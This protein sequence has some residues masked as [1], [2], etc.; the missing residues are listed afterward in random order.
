MIT[1]RVGLHFSV[2]WHLGNRLHYGNGLEGKQQPIYHPKKFG[3]I[4]RGA[5]VHLTVH[6]GPIGLPLIAKHTEHQEPN[7]FT[8]N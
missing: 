8:D 4:S 5:E 1:M 6:Q 3:D 7:G 2:W